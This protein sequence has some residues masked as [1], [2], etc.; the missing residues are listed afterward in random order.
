[1]KKESSTSFGV[2]LKL[3]VGIAFIAMAVSFYGFHIPS[4]VL[5]VLIQSK[6]AVHG[7]FGLDLIL[8]E[9]VSPDPISS[10]VELGY[11]NALQ[12]KII[13]ICR[14]WFSDNFLFQDWLDRVHATLLADFERRGVPKDNDSVFEIPTFT[15]D[16]ISPQKF[17]VDYVK[18]GKPVIIKNVMD[19]PAMKWTPDMLAERAG[20]FFTT[21][22]C[23]DG[24]TRKWTLGDYVRSRNDTAHPCYFDNNADVFEAKSFLEDELQIYRFG[25]Y[26]TGVKS[27]KGQRPSS[28][29]F[30]Q[31]FMSVFNTTGALMHCANYNNLFYMVHGKKKWTFVDPVNSFLIYPM[32]N[33]M[34]KDSKSF[35]TWH[36]LHANNSAEIINKQFPLYRYCP[37]YIY[38][39]EKGDILLNPPW[40]WH[41]VENVEVE[42]IGVASR[43]FMVSNYP[44]TNGLFSFLQAT[45]WEFT[46][47]MYKK[48][49]SKAGKYD[50]KYKPTSHQD[51]DMQ[52][53]FGNYGSVYQ[54]RDFIKPLMNPTA[55]EGYISYLKSKNFDFDSN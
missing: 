31:M 50:F 49:A 45:S 25:E 47:F 17:F 44:W 33:P 22:R 43:W 10:Y 23:M 37:K 11:F 3:S 35:L 24:S 20:D 48:I 18:K 5:T 51:L 38:T 34:M 1:M 46:D 32:F 52:V 7:W 42:S 13:Y 26:M 8:H 19:I 21:N 9:A 2:L 4:L 30:S 6:T 55:W 14:K 29:V 27:E 15:M 53:N 16:Q 28:Y 39:L 41:Q 12:L 40:N 54:H 36:V